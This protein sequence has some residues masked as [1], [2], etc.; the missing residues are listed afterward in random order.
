MKLKTATLT[1][2]TLD[3]AVAK[4]ESLPLMYDPM[5]FGR[6]DPDAIQSGWW[7]WSDKAHLIVGYTKTKPNQSEGYS[8]A[9]NWAQGGPIIEREGFKLYQSGA[10]DWFCSN[11]KQGNTVKVYGETPLI[12]AMRCYVASKLGEEIQIP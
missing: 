3:L 7:I 12:A 2:T 10:G 1:G 6:T 9:T 4:A 8:P 11:Y 5:G